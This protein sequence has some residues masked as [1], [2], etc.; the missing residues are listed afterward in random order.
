[1]VS[2]G[3]PRVHPYSCSRRSFY[4]GNHTIAKLNQL[5]N[6]KRMNPSQF[7]DAIINEIFD[8]SVAKVND[9][10]DETGKKEDLCIT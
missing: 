8:D 2:K 7:I 4:L 5:C 3:R 6:T 10:D 1:M 9:Y